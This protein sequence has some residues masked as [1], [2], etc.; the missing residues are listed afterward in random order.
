MNDRLRIAV[1]Q[2]R[3][4]DG[5]HGDTLHIIAVHPELA[6][7]TVAPSNFINGKISERIF[8]EEFPNGYETK[9]IF[10]SV[11]ITANKKRTIDDFIPSVMVEKPDRLLQI[12]GNAIICKYVLGE[13]LPLSID[14]VATVFER[15]R[16]NP[17]LDDIEFKALF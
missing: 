9:V 16:F 2:I 8:D 10:D 11:A 6:A 14:E 1:T 15:I 3:N 17:M 7:I 13:Y 4:R 5:F 12:F